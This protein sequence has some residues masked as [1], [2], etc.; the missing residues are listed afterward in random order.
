M[1]R[2]ERCTQFIWHTLVICHSR[3][4]PHLVRWTTS[5]I[6]FFFPKQTEQMV[7]PKPSTTSH[8]GAYLFGHYIPIIIPFTFQTAIHHHQP[9][10]R[11]LAEPTWGNPSSPRCPKALSRSRRSAKY[12]AGWYLLCHA[13]WNCH[14]WQI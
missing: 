11:L 1:V 7:D 6:A 8:I 5:N 3:T 2:P 4:I 13:L 12:K 10:A 9:D 14:S